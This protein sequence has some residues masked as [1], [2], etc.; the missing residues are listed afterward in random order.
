VV[1]KNKIQ[2]LAKKL[3][4]ELKKQGY[5]IYTENG[6]HIDIWHHKS[7]NDRVYVENCINDWRIDCGTYENKLN[8]R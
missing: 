1:T 5:D 7:L 3:L 6:G 8:K 2:T 4:A